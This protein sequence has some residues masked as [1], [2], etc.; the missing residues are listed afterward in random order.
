[1]TFSTTENNFL[2]DDK[3]IPIH[4]LH[5]EENFELHGIRIH[6]MASTAVE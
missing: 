6:F 3:I 5:L 2:K 4:L 1:M